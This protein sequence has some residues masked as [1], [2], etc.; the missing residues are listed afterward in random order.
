[1]DAVS[2]YGGLLY[3]NGGSGSIVQALC[4]MNAV[5]GTAVHLLDQRNLTLSSVYKITDA[6][7]S[8]GIIIS[9]NFEGQPWRTHAQSYFEFD[10]ELKVTVLFALIK[11]DAALFGECA[12][13]LWCIPPSISQ[14]ESIEWNHQSTVF[15]TQLDSSSGCLPANTD[16]LLLYLWT[17][18]DHTSGAPTLKQVLDKLVSPDDL[19]IHGIIPQL[20]Y[21]TPSSHN[22]NT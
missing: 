4:R 18:L 16:C 3:P 9:G 19:I 15:V 1:M 12:C 13:S 17:R 10:S 8:N 20:V 2:R 22:S 6:T 5:R 21:D 11:S 7:D 14:K